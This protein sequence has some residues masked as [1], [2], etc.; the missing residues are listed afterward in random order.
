[1]TTSLFFSFFW[2]R[3]APNPVSEA[4]VYTI[5]GL[6]KSG[7]C[8]IGAVINHFFSYSKAVCCLVIQL[9]GVSFFNN[10]IIGLAIWEKSFINFW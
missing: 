2:D 1:M 7:Y 8:K 5:N 10:S 9:K 3:T 4:S 6:L